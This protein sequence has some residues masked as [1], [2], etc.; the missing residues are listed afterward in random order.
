VLDAEIAITLRLGVEF[1]PGTRVASANALL[2]GSDAVLVAAGELKEGDA[3]RFGLPTTPQGIEVSKHTHESPVKGV[4]AAG[5]AVRSSKMAVRS[6]AE[7]KAAALAIHQY[8][9][10]QTV[11]GA[12]RPFTTRIGPLLDGELERFL[13]E[14][15][16]SGR[17]VPARDGFSADEARAEARRC[18]H[19]D[20]RKAEHCKLRHVCSAYEA[21]TTRYKAPRRPFEQHLLPGGLIY[22]PGKCIACG[23]CVQIAAEAG[24]PLDLTFVGR[25][26]NVRVRE[27]FGAAEAS[28]VSAEL[29]AQCVAACPTGALAL[30]DGQALQ[31]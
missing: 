22:E 31:S 5:G 29:A 1:R 24:E 9:S 17:I 10:G 8:L 27:A 20:C 23:L 19:C 15:S 11:A 14:A 13:A 6:L 7:G 25:G 4:F 28:T 2:S 18:L 3:D 26:F 21:R 12:A 16:R 30:R